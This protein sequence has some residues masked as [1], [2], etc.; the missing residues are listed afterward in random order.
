MRN[1]LPEIIE[2]ARLTTGVLG[3]EP[4]SGPNGCFAVAG[5]RGNVL[6]I[7]ATDGED[8]TSDGWEHVSVSLMTRTPL[9]EEMA[10]VKDMFFE[11]DETVIQFHPAKRDYVNCHPFCLHMWRH[12]DGHTLP[13]SILVGPKTTERI[14]L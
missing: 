11:E 13:P 6:R 8:K 2:L 3:S 7:I 4:H 9:W 14:T 10:W 5:P 1:T 12:R